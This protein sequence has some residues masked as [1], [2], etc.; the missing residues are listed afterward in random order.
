[1]S[2]RHVRLS[3]HHRVDPLDGLARQSQTVERI[4][5]QAGLKLPRKQPKRKRL[6]LNDGSCIRLR[7]AYPNHV[8][9]YD[10]VTWQTAN[11]R[12]LMVL[13]VLDEFMRECLALFVA[14]RITADD[15]LAQVEEL[16]LFRGMLVVRRNG[17]H[18]Q[19][20]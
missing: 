4:W 19:L 18:F 8:W 11:G 15:V 14:L 20:S 16:F 3:H 12:P 6:W 17:T 1:M 13:S 10:F 2:V 5:R 7:P 9:S